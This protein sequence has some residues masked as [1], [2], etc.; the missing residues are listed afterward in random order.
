MSCGEL[1]S[2][3]V[4]LFSQLRRLHFFVISRLLH[5]LY[6]SRGKPTIL[7]LIVC[8]VD[9]TGFN[10]LFSR[11][12]LRRKVYTHQQLDKTQ[13]IETSPKGA[14]TCVGSTMEPYSASVIEWSSLVHYKK[15]SSDRL[16]KYTF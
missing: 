2:A 6:G 7:N 4:Q 1:Y 16:P 9:L 12:A 5:L 8:R 13:L 10:V 11:H 14:S 15:K 3:V